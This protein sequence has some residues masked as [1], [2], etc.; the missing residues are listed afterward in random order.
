MVTFPLNTLP[1]ATQQFPRPPLFPRAGSR[2]R[3]AAVSFVLSWSLGDNKR[4][5]HSCSIGEEKEESTSTTPRDGAND[6]NSGVLARSALLVEFPSD[7]N[8][9]LGC[10]VGGDSPGDVARRADERAREERERE[11]GR[12]A[13]VCLGIFLEKH[14]VQEDTVD[15]LSSAGWL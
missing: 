3:E 4:E 2:D 15:V 7:E 1:R 10:G 6:V 9:A 11:E 12:E 5:N 13:L 14:E 8:G